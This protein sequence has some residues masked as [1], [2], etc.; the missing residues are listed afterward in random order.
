M[1]VGALMG[2]AHVEHVGFTYRNTYFVR[3]DKPIQ[4]V[5]KYE[6]FEKKLF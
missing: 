4:D 2:C 5:M 3:A 6:S 1:V